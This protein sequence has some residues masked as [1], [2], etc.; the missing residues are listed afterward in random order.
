MDGVCVGTSCSK[1]THQHLPLFSSSIMHGGRGDEH[2]GLDAEL[3]NVIDYQ[4]Q[5]G[6]VFRNGHMLPRRVPVY[7][8]GKCLWG[9]RAQ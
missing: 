4:L 1:S 3:P 6:S 8:C 7:V 2:Y 9:G 5:V